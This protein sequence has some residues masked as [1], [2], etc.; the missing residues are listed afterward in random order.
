M[1]GIVGHTNRQLEMDLY[2][3]HPKNKDKA[4]EAHAL[5]N[6]WTAWLFQAV[7]LRLTSLA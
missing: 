2:Y 6:S 1:N 5:I 7:Y 4:L 3:H